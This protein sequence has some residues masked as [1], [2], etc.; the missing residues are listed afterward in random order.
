MSK[1]S[2]GTTRDANRRRERHA[3]RSR[4]GRLQR[5]IF[6]LV[7]FYANQVAP[8]ERE[9]KAFAQQLLGRE[10]ESAHF[11]GDVLCVTEKA[12]MSPFITLDFEMGHEAA[13]SLNRFVAELIDTRARFLSVL[14]AR[15]RQ[16]TGRDVILCV[17][18]QEIPA[19]PKSTLEWRQP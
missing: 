8:V 4:L 6:E 16:P 14:Q 9:A 7:S 12:T 17:D 15:Q 10:V 19:V 11:E 5:R 2:R 13:Q 1:R 18:G 3:R